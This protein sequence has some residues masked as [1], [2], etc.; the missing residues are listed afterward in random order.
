MRGDILA[1]AAL[2][3]EPFYQLVR[4]Q[5]L[6]HALERSS[7]EGATRVRVVHVLPPANDAYQRSLASP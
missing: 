5:L 2:F 4:Q 3:D 1:V 6:A 7:A